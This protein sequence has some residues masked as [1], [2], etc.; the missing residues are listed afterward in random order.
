MALIPIHEARKRGKFWV[1][2]HGSRVVAYYIDAIP[3]VVVK[4]DG[5]RTYFHEN[6]SRLSREVELLHPER[7][8]KIPIK[9][10]PNCGEEI[11]I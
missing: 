10:C 1:I 6:D 7:G 4:I 5:Q 2:L 3:R 9:T 8:E 11:E